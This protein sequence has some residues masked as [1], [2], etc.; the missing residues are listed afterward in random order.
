[1][2]ICS[3]PG[4]SRFLYSIILTL[5]ANFRLKNRMRS[6]DEADPGLHTGL[7]YL[8]PQMEYKAHILKHASQKDVRTCS[9]D[10]VWSSHTHNIRLTRVADSKR[11]RTLRRNSRPVFDR[12]NWRWLVCMRTP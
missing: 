10:I 5:D 1:M 7:A 12:R 4:Y 2:I 6:S 9:E 8:V 11:W 3:Y